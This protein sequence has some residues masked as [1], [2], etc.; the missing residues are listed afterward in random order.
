MSGP[1][2]STP[3]RGGNGDG[4]IDCSTLSVDTTL[5]SPVPAVLSSL[6]KGSKLNVVLEKLPS[7][8]DILLAKTITNETA[9]SLTPPRFLDIIHCLQSGHCY[10]AEVLANPSGGECRVR[11]RS[12]TL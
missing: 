6:A 3:P 11:I 1:G 10:I 5:N 12:G 7:N 4:G 8:R 9:G 2:G